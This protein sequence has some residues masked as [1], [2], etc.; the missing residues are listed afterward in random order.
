MSGSGK[1]RRREMKLLPA[2]VERQRRPVLDRIRR[3]LACRT[4]FHG[5]TVLVYRVAGRT[6]DRGFVRMDRRWHQAP[7]TFQGDGL[8]Q[9]AD[10]VL[11]VHPVALE[12]IVTQNPVGVVTGI[13][14]DLVVGHVVRS[15]GPGGVFL[16]MTLAAAGVQAAADVLLPEQEPSL[17]GTGTEDYFCDGWGFRE[18][19]GPF[20][21]TPL[22]EGYD[23]GNR[24]NAYRWHIPDPITFKKS[25]R[26]EIQ[27]KGGQDFP[28][29]TS[30]GF[31]ERDG[32]CRERAAGGSAQLAI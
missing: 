10:A 11:E 17:R 29:G 7:G 18:Q 31:I 13:E 25:L 15:G 30:T 9:V 20:Y 14:E 2:V 1:H 24:G 21:G 19:S 27:H 23:P 3:P 4:H 6:R 16:L 8:D 12:T 5:L 22:W 32:L 28:D 26:V